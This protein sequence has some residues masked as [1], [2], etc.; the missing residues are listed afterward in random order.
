[1]SQENRL[2]PIVP[3][4]D[5]PYMHSLYARVGL[6][7]S[8]SA[9]EVL[10][11]AEAKWDAAQDIGERVETAELLLGRRIDGLEVPTLPGD[12]RGYVFDGGSFSSFLGATSL[13][14]EV[15]SDI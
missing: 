7:V 5:H 11:V 4:E 3:P 10:A 8:A 14:A 2:V 12:F 15:S 9:D 1:M 13:L 6:E